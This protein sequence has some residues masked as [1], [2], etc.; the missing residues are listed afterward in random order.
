VKVLLLNAGPA[1][2]ATDLEGDPATLAERLRA[3]LARRTGHVEPGKR[4]AQL[5]FARFE[6]PA[7]RLVAEVPRETE[8]GE[9]GF[10]STGSLS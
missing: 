5:V 3:G 4:I 7:I 9:D 1:L 8:R 6:R 2:E 10:G